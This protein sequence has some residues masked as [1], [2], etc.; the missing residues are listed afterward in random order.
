[1]PRARSDDSMMLGGERKAPNLAP[2]SD[3]LNCISDRESDAASDDPA[4]AGIE[5]FGRAHAEAFAHHENEPHAFAGEPFG[6]HVE[7]GDD[8]LPLRI[9]ERPIGKCLRGSLSLEE[10]H[11]GT[12]LVEG[13]ENK[14][15]R[16]L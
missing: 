10:R 8:F 2:L 7:M 14:I 3:D 13:I 1:M 4:R 5:H 12:H 15:A 16:A 11:L 9:R 6:K